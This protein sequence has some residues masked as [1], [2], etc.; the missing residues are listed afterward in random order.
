MPGKSV[1]FAND[2]LKLIFHG[3]PIANVADNA[4]SSPLTEVYVAL[5]TADP[6]EA[7]TQS[8]NEV[9]YTG[10]ARKSR[11]R[12]AGHWT[13]TNDV[14]SPA[15]DIDFPSREDVGSTSA[16]HF[17]IGV[18]AS[19]ASK[20]LYLGTLSPAIT[21]TQGVTPRIKSTSTITEQ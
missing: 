10:Y 11:V 1:V 5:H 12:T 8:T 3:T 13:V 15:V 17:S 7:G 14:V 6:G 19:G 9:S 18:A 21:I 16:T 2:L 20:I 4:A